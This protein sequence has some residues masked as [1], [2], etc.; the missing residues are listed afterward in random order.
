MKT[1]FLTIIF[2]YVTSVAKAAQSICRECGELEGLKIQFSKVK[3]AKPTDGE[4]QFA[5]VSKMANAIA[6]LPSLDGDLAESQTKVVVSIFYLVD[7]E[8]F[9]EDILE[10]NPHVFEDNRAAFAKLLKDGNNRAKQ[11]L[12]D[13]D[14][15]ILAQKYGQSPPSAVIDELGPPPGKAPKAA[16]PEN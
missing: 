12:R 5:I 2:L 4:A 10:S 6:R 1:L 14:S 7:D 13:I 15:I 16:T 3:A 8:G 11:I 9:R